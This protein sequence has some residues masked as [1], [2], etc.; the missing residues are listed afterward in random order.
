MP[1][2]SKES[3]NNNSALSYKPLEIGLPWKVL[4]FSV[5]VFGFSLFA[6]FGLSVGYESYLDSRLKSLD[7][8][9][10]KLA[11]QVGQEDQQKL[12]SF[13]SQL[14]N[15]EKVLKEHS[16]SIQTFKSLE[17]YTLP[18][19]TFTKADFDAGERKMKLEGMANTLDTLIEQMSV[20]D[21][22]KELE[23]KSV[24]EQIGFEKQNVSFVL[25]IYFKPDAL[26]KL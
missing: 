19:V 17:K 20:F 7:D 10:D 15:L 24:L 18:L 12:V 25:V 2:S 6:Y 23:G 5:I 1:I 8:G 14:I 13:Y 16:F 26:S 21:G 3:Q 11:A 4:L 22:A 9:I